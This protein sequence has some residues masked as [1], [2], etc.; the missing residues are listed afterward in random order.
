MLPYCL[1]FRTKVRAICWTRSVFVW[2]GQNNWKCKKST[3]VFYGVSIDFWN[4]RVFEFQNNEGLFFDSLQ[5]HSRFVSIRK[6]SVFQ[7]SFRFSLKFILPWMFVLFNFKFS[8]LFL[9]F[10][11]NDWIYCWNLEYVYPLQHSLTYSPSH[12]LTKKAKVKL[13]VSHL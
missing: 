13:K 2:C 1:E 7:L 5:T 11:T 12:Y 4:G 3:Q 8:A 9:L 6:E 10:V